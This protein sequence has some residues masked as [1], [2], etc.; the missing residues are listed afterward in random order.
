VLSFSVVPGGTCS[1]FAHYPTD[2]SVGYFLSPWRAGVTGLECFRLGR[3]FFLH[4]FRK[5]VKLRPRMHTPKSAHTK[6]NAYVMWFLIELVVY[7]VVV[8]AYYFLVLHFLGGWLKGLFD[9]HRLEYAATALALMVAQ[10]IGLELL[11]G[12][13]FTKIRGKA[14]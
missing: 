7:A 9:A 3:K 1:F 8:V 13:F 2:E 12:W 4:N 14:K 5:Q 6:E 11:T 10:G